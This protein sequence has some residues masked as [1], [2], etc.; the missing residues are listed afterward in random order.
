MLRAGKAGTQ[1]AGAGFGFCPVRGGI[2]FNSTVPGNGFSRFRLFRHA[3][4]FL[5]PDCL[6]GFAGAQGSFGGSLC[7]SQP[8]AGIYG[9][10]QAV[11][12]GNASA[13][14]QACGPS[15]ERKTLEGDC[16]VYRAWRAD[17]PPVADTRSADIGMAVLSVYIPGS[18]SGGLEN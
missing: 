6:A 9:N 18:F 11:G 3:V 13:G 10:R 16:P 7:A 14:P 12:G 1:E 4:P 8:S 2:L 17:S 5:Y 15:P